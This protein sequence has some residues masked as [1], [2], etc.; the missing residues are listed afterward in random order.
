MFGKE[1]HPANYIKTAAQR[2][3]SLLNKIN[4]L[5]QGVKI[6]V[7]TVEPVKWDFK[8]SSD[9]NDQSLGAL[10]ATIK[11][12]EDSSATDNIYFADI[13]NKMLV[14]FAPEDFWDDLHLSKQGAVKDANAWFD[15]LIP[16]L[17]KMPGTLSTDAD[18]PGKPG[19]V[20]KK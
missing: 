20:F 4:Q 15:A 8:W 14:N 11:S 5:K 7:G 1:T 10:N 18:K 19:V 13:R 6:I 17:R 12:I 2:F 16:V 9:A 3:R